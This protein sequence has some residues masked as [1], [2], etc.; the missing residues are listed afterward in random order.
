MKFTLPLSP[1]YVS[2]WG[3]WEA[4][5][6]I[7]QNAMDESPL[8]T[9]ELNDGKLIITS[10]TGRLT[11]QSLVLGVSSKRDDESKRGKFGEG[12]KLALLVLARLLHPVSIHTGDEIWFAKLEEDE[13]FGTTLLTV[14][15]VQSTH[16]EPGVKFVIDYVGESDFAD[17]QGNIRS[18]SENQILDDPEEEGRLYVGGL[19]VAKVDGFKH[20]Y[21]FLPGVVKLDR[22]RGM[23]DGFDLGYQTSALWTERGGKR[24]IELIEEEAPDVQY[25]EYHST[26]TSALALSSLN[27]FHSA[28]GLHAI[29]VSTQDEIQRATK[30]GIKWVLVPAVLKNVLKTV[31]SWFIPQ[32]KSALELL[33]DFRDKHYGK[34]SQAARKDLDDII[35]SLTLQD[36][37]VAQS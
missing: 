29:P 19:F 32:A 14:H 28:Y 2:H 11:P 24:A 3:L 23:V 20:G 27:Y 18:N 17:I 8:S 7:V 34:L 21:S 30:A 12:Y 31:K 16:T 37:P 4:V 10:P 33:E 6:E 15:T 35:D 36:E 13:T 25:V 1:D 22:D 5:R 26:P 9:I